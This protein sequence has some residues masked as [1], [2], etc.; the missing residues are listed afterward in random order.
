MVKY[1]GVST[2]D[3]LMHPRVPT[4]ILDKARY[5]LDGYK[6]DTKGLAKSDLEMAII[7]VC[8]ERGI[9]YKGQWL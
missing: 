5:I 3:R 8:N 7:L 6:V 4:I 2:T 9:E 1:D